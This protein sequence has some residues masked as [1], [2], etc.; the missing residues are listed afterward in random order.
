M[1]KFSRRGALKLAGVL[2]SLGLTNVPLGRAAAA[3]ADTAA[4]ADLLVARARLGAACVAAFPHLTPSFVQAELAGVGLAGSTDAVALQWISKRINADFEAGR[5]LQ[6]DG[7][8][9]AQTEA[10]VY[11]QA[12]FDALAS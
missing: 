8:Y 6:V 5:M 7:W 12:H 1:N 9:L 4:A 11:A 2:A 10:L 3:H